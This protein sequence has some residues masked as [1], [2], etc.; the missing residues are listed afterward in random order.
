MTTESS[1]RS[2][3]AMPGKPPLPSQ[4]AS[5]DM[6]PVELTTPRLV[7]RPPRS[8]D[9]LQIF[10][11]YT[12]DAEV[13][14]YMIWRPHDDLAQTQAFIDECV[15]AFPQ[16]DKRAYV[17]A[18]RAAPDVPIGMLE[19]RVAGHAVDLGYVLARKYWG[20]GLMP[21]AIGSL[22]SAVLGQRE[23]FRVQ[24]T[25]DVEN[26]RSARTLEKAGFVREGRLERYTVHPNIGSEPR[27]S[28]MYA[29]CR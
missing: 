20:A 1:L 17:L 24:A 11:A 14:R 25:C 6:L 23:F 18:T 15:R 2:I 21:E 19:A 29:K 7:I 8:A 16:G 28:Y 22:A 4:G 13:A 27:P 10:D 9:A 12:Q 26:A 5:T 3:S